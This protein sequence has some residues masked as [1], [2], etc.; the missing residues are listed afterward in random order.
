[1]IAVSVDPAAAQAAGA[2]DDEAVRRRLDVGAES[3]QAV[4]DGGD[5]V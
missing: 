4:D 1:M 5:A 2:A 3:A